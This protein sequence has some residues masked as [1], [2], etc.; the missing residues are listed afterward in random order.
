[1]RVV[2]PRGLVCV[3]VCAR[4]C[5]F[6][7]CV[8][9]CVCVQST[10]ADVTRWMTTSGLALPPQP[11]PFFSQPVSASHLFA[12]VCLSVCL[13]VSA[14]SIPQTVSAH[15]HPFVSICLSVCLSPPLS[16]S[17]SLTLGS[18]GMRSRKALTTARREPSIRLWAKLYVEGW[19]LKC[20]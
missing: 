13:S 15:L 4:V 8:C 19:N 5:V 17:I 2:A 1:M 12:S 9:V 10:E 14:L 20:V 11:R 6:V 7:L 3:C 18:V 16:I